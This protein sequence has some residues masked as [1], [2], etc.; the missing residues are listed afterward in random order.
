VILAGA[1]THGIMRGKRIPIAE[2]ARAAERGI[3]LCDVIWALPVDEVAGPVQPPPGHAGYFPRTGYPDMLAVPDLETA[4]IVPW[5][6]H[7]ALLLCD[8]VDDGGSAISLSPRAVLR[9]VVER[10]RSMGFEPIVGVELELY[11]L[12]ETPRSVL[13]KRPS[14]LVAVEEQPSVYGVVAASRQE[15]FAGTVRE[16]LLRYGL[17]V[18]ACNPE[19]GPGQFEINLRAAPALQAADEGF[20]LKHAVKEVA[21]GQGLLATFMAKPRSD[22]PG[23]SCH[24]HLS[25][26]ERDSDV[27]QDPADGM[28]P[29]MRHFI[30]GL[31]SGMAEL[32]ALFA[33]TPNSY[34][35]LVPHSWAGTTATW[36]VDNR[37]AGLRAICRGDGATRVEQRQAGA[38]ANPYLAVSAALAAGLDG[39][40][41]GCEPP[42]PVDGDVYALADSAAPPLPATLG[43]ATDLLE[44]SALA[45][46]WLG[47][48]VVEHCVAM[49]R[50]ELAAQAAAVTDWETARYLEVL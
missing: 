3:A 19:A 15:P 2:M 47:D 36:G 39:L 41:R 31:L 11:L 35:R 6:E 46:D 10:A 34:R 28:S 44:R 20:L 37:S 22:W 4:R 40:R 43:E 18:E 26:R 33:P 7:T 32:S 38:D 16:T 24:L 1:D 50:S 21:A 29:A 49:R 9:S 27:F 12:R 23:S 42:A 5:H 48:D 8:F 45:R 25:L 30:G 17:G 13:V 14:Q